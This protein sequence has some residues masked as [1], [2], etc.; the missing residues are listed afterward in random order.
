M[1]TQRYVE[2]E[3]LTP[4]EAAAELRVTAST[5]KRWLRDGKLP[6][7]L[8]PSGVWRIPVCELRALR[9]S[10]IQNHRRRDARAETRE[11]A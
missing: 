4:H 11:P 2:S 8:L 6:G 5:V 7:V 1:A 10:Q 9:T 3:L